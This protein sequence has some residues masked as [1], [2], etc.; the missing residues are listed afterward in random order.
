MN[1]FESQFFGTEL[2]QPLVSLSAGI[3]AEIRRRQ[4]V[5]SYRSI[6]MDPNHKLNCLMRP[7]RY[8]SLRG[9]RGAAKSRGAAEALIRY[10]DRGYERILC[11]REYQNSI[12]DSVHRLLTD[13]IDRMGLT[14]RFD[15]TQKSISH[16]HTRSEFLFKGLRMNVQEIKSTEGITKCWV[17][18]AQNTSDESLKVLVPTIREEN[19]EIWFTWNVTDIEAPV[20]KRFADPESIAAMGDDIYS[21]EINYDENP[22]FPEVLRKEMEFLKRTDYEAYLHVWK[23]HP[24]KISDSVILWKKCRVSDFPDDLWQKANRLHFGADFGFARDPST[25]IRSFIIDNTLY[26]EHEAYG[27]GIEINEMAAFYRTVPESEKWPIKCDSSRPET[28]SHMR[29]EGF[30][31]QAAEKWSGCV[32]DGI[33]HIKGFDEIV[34]HPRCTHTL[35]EMKLYS[36]KK[37]KTSGEVLPIVVDKHNHVID[38]IRYSLDGYI[39]A[40]GDLG[41][42]AKFGKGYGGAPRKPRER[43]AT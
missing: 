25:L 4:R 40:R 26:V 17:E 28:I 1:P 37:D 22:Y 29:G 15:I 38:A 13:Q 42:W 20:Y 10:A 27:V 7:R 34:I 18:E 8:K 12:A 11:T 21:Y 3:Q 35:Q 23:G 30:D 5:K 32:E 31:T 14:H 16:K 2:A 41:V 9:G 43:V 39:Q 33:A 24:I 19:S 36:Y 6:V